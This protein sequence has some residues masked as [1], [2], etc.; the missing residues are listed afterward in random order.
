MKS[1]PEQSSP[2][3]TPQ[4]VQL[5][6]KEG[7]C[8]MPTCFPQVINLFKKR[9]DMHD[10]T[11]ANDPRHF[12][13]DQSYSAPGG[14]VPPR[15]QQKVFPSNLNEIHPYAPLGR[16][17]NANVVCTRSG[18]IGAMIVCPALFPPA[19]RAQM[20]VSA[21]SISTSLPL[22]SSPHCA[23]RTAVTA[24]IAIHQPRVGMSGG[25]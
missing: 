18:P 3:R 23:P 24:P 1:L 22:P 10:D 17:W 5:I 11:G 6:G 4:S 12:R 8:T 15:Y 21:D 2:V 7:I 19:K 20:S 9:W 16:R 13:V 14:T 25:A